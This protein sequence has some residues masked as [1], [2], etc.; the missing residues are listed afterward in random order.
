MDF[1]PLILGTMVRSTPDDAH[2]VDLF[3]QAYEAGITAFDTA[4]LYG[5]GVT[6]QLLGQALAQIPRDRVLVLSKV[7]LRW[8]AGDQ[9]QVFF[10][11]T[12][13][14]GQRLVVRR[15]SRPESVVEEVE[16]SLERLGI[17]YID[18]MQIHQP[19]EDTPIGDTMAALVELQNQGRIRAIG[20]SNFSLP[21]MRQA[22]D[23]LPGQRLAS[24]QMEY[25]LLR[26]NIE[27]EITPWCAAHDVAVLAYSPL[28]GGELART[29]LELTRPT[30]EQKGVSVTALVMAWL[31]HRPGCTSVIGGASTID[32]VIE[33]LAAV[34]VDL[35]PEQ[36]E[37]IGR[38]FE[39]LQIVHP[40]ER[41]RLLRA[42]AR[43]RSLLLR[44]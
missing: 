28:A 36:V 37:R 26:Q 18:V 5:F 15:N 20:V 34:K 2:R 4:P 12:T 9:G 40:W 8:D 21:Q 29:L 3:V 32:Q 16:R 44:R 23:A 11:H 24:V 33:Q 31:L 35:S 17:D 30:A 42:A 25:N 43:L 13:P 41:N 39:P 1:P 14:D 22:R 10:E 6:E 19:D 27:R 7:G 38:A